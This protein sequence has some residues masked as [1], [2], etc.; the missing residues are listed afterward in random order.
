MF[1]YPYFRAFVSY[2]MTVIAINFIVPLAVMFYC[3]LHITRAIRRHVAGDRPPNLSGDWSD[4]VDVT[5]VGAQ[6]FER[7]CIIKFSDQCLAES[8][9]AL[10]QPPVVHPRVH[11]QALCPGICL[12]ISNYGTCLSTA[13][14]VLGFSIAGLSAMNNEDS[15]L[16]RYQA[17]LHF[18]SILTVSRLTAFD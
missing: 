15:A 1:A 4:Q 8:P 12:H 3:Y 10:P 2:T 13:W 7:F 18:L 14:V 16:S 17:A 5:K 9:A 11:S 6:I